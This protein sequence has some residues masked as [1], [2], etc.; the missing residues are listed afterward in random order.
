M[1]SVL[2]GIRLEDGCRVVLPISSLGAAS[3]GG[4]EAGE[5]QQ[6]AVRKTVKSRSG[7]AVVEIVAVGVQHQTAFAPWYREVAVF[8]P[9]PAGYVAVRRCQANCD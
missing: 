8:F 5:P 1:A 3:A 6:K 4:G 9:E 7:A 2:D